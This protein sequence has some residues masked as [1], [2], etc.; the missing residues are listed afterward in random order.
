MTTTDAI[1][2]TGAV[3]CEYPELIV[4]LGPPS[5]DP[6]GDADTFESV[7][8]S[9]VVQSA[10]GSRLD[11]ADLTYLLDDHL[12]D[13]DQPASFARMIAIQLPD[14]VKTRLHLGDYVGES[15]KILKEGES[16]TA[17]S[18]LRSYHFGSPVVGYDVWSPISS[19]EEVIESDIIFNPTVDDVTL[20]NM[21]SK[22]RDGKEG[23]LWT[24]PET[25]QTD[26]GALY[27]TVD[28]E[29]WTLRRAVISICELLNPNEEFIRNPT[30]ADIA[31][32]VDAPA[33]RDVIIAMGT[34]L[35]QS[36]D[37][38]LIPHGFNWYVDY[39]TATEKPQITVFK[40]GDG[41]EKTLFLQPPGEVLNLEWSNVNQLVI[42]NGIG[43]S[44]NQVRVFGQFEEVEV[45]LPLYPAWD[46]THD[47]LTVDDLT[48]DGP[49]YAGKETVHRLWVAN[50]AGDIDE[51]ESR[52]GIS[53]TVPDLSAVFT[54]WTPHR[55]TLNE[56]LT[57]QG[58]TITGN[59]QRRPIF[60]E[61]SIDAG[62]TWE[63]AKDW[64]AKLCPDQIGILF[65]ADSPPTELIDAGENARV[66]VTGTLFGDKRVEGL[67]TKQAWAVNG[68]TVELVLNRPDKFQS[69]WRQTIGDFKSVFTDQSPLP[70][71]DERDDTEE[72]LLYAET[73]R[74]Q[75]HYADVTCEF[76]LPGWHLEY[77]IGDLISK[78]EGRELN[79]DASPANA[80][81][82]R[83][84]QI[85]E[86]RFENGSGGPS[87]VL[88]V[89]RGI[90]E[91]AASRMTQITRKKA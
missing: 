27:Q 41:E 4:L 70:E 51:T 71:A 15:L 91:N 75:N 7:Y 33:I 55:R 78:I 73:L 61:Y 11:Y 48:K 66:R 88:I 81:V 34:F 76:R 47:S 57:F 13:R 53:P 8:C 43:D 44:A 14:T 32:L 35:P 40:I 6:P 69:R 59:K 62:L 21:S 67:A 24:H 26:D 52:W 86:R 29:E 79:L 64:G 45:T 5:A 56:P 82:A 87:T 63:P 18:Q 46:A 38:L 49:E 17:Q 25:S 22:I 37:M 85:M 30:Y 74:D 77:K 9:R 10:G 80:P 68:R 90:D 39:D 3:F 50:E 36:L 1:N 72:I 58:G 16:L 28:R 84:V 65:D 19:S 42:D 83:Y 12:K 31:V 20:I 60:I 89:D 23:R 2:T 54:R